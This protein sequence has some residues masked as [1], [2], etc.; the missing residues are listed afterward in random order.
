MIHTLLKR[1]KK[2]RVLDTKSRPFSL[3][4][5]LFNKHKAGIMISWWTIFFFG[6]QSMILR[7]SAD[8]ESLQPWLSGD[9]TDG[10]KGGFLRR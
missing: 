9:C 5:S 4:E 7:N 3:L 2:T 1:R 6:L 8:R 10:R